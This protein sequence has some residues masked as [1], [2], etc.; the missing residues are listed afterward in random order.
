MQ[1]VLLRQKNTSFLVFVS[2]FSLV[3]GKIM[4]LGLCDFG[5]T[6]QC[7]LERD[8]LIYLCWFQ[9]TI[10]SFLNVLWLRHRVVVIH[11]PDWVLINSLTYIIIKTLG[12]ILNNFP[13]IK[14]FSYPYILRKKIKN[15]SEINKAIISIKYSPPW[16]ETYRS[17][18][19]DH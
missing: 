2:F 6:C 12:R 11:S 8:I 9:K 7:H 3:V 1:P 13:E 10:C 17:F 15:L 18:F 16:E 5:F 4:V 14:R 19:R